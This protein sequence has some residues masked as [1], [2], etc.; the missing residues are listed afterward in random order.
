VAWKRLPQAR[1]SHAVEIRV[2][3]NRNCFGRSQREQS[4]RCE[5]AIST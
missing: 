3:R 4:R 1:A 5:I 2:L